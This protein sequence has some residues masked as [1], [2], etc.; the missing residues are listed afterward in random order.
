MTANYRW[1]PPPQDRCGRF[2][3]RKGT[4]LQTTAE[5]VEAAEDVEPYGGGAADLDR[6]RD[7]LVGIEAWTAADA[8]TASRRDCA[9]PLETASHRPLTADRRQKTEDGRRP[10]G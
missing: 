5:A 4:A 6:G 7:E 10:N 2:T 8:A 3:R 1:L 9:T